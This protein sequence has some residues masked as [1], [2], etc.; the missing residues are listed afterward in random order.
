MAPSILLQ[1]FFTRRDESIDNNTKTKLEGCCRVS[2]LVVVPRVYLLHGF[3]N[4]LRREGVNR[5]TP[6]LV[7]GQDES[8]DVIFSLALSE[9]GQK[10]RE[11]VR[12]KRTN[13]RVVCGKRES[14]SL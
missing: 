13:L 8:L 10:T 5:R 2:D 12:T 9:P 6:S 7:V 3:V 4:D 1:T 14:Q 11:I